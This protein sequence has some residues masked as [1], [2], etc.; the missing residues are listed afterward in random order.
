MGRAENATVVREFYDAVI[1][2]DADRIASVIDAS[3]AEDASITW[4]ASLP[5]GGTLTSARTLRKVF[6][7]LATSEGGP[8]GL[9]VERIVAGDDDVVAE[10]SFDFAGVP[11]GALERW[12]FAGDRVTEIKAFYWDTA[13]ILAGP[14]SS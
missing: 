10:V 12:T 7:G 9:T 13:A 8:A 2:K 5:H 4:P 14:A 6:G 3:F 11:S 1:A